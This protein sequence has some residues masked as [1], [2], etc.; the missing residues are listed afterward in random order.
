[1]SMATFCKRVPSFPNTSF[2]NTS[3]NKSPQPKPVATGALT[4]ELWFPPS[5]PEPQPSQEPSFQP[6][7]NSSTNINTVASLCTL[8]SM[9]PSYAWGVFPS[10]ERLGMRMAAPRQPLPAEVSG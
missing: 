8:N 10:L 4:P 5:D 6:L 7:G 9:H 3:H 1:M 2:P